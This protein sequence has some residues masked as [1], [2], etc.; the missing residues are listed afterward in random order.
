LDSGPGPGDVER[1]RQMGLD[2]YI[3]LQLNP[4]RI[5]DAVA[6]D[7]INDLKVLSM[8]TAELYE[9]Y[10]SRAN[11]CGSF[12]SETIYRRSWPQRVKARS[13]GPGA[14]QGAT[15]SAGAPDMKN[16]FRDEGRFEGVRGSKRK[17]EAGRYFKN[18][19]DDEYRKAIRDYYI[20]NNLQQPQ[21]IVQELQASRILMA[22]YSERQLQEE[23]VDFWSNHSISLLE[24][25]QIGGCWYLTTGIRFVLT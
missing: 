20:Q 9:K 11:C 25:A 6:N 17:P 23:M 4:E 1:V 10:P 15:P 5:P 7:K 19:K 24:R 3:D 12:R 21:K 14:V 18:G 2:K 22:V 16:D 8:T 13:E